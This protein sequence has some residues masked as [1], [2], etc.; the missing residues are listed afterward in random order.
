MRN[1]F[2]FGATPFAGQHIIKLRGLI[3]P[4]RRAELQLLSKNIVVFPSYYK[5]KEYTYIEGFVPFSTYQEILKEFKIAIINRKIF[6]LLQDAE[7]LR[8][9]EIAE[10]PDYL[11]EM[12]H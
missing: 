9:P 7:E 6:D 5:G 12:P 1:N 10:M 2:P 4:E 3:Q 8:N 11:G